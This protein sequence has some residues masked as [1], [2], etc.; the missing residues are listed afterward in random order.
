[1]IIVVCLVIWCIFKSRCS[2]QDKEQQSQEGDNEV[3]YEEPDLNVVTEI[4]LSENQAYG[5]VN[6]QRRRN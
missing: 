1:M 5:R 2:L 6:R 4:S 3:I